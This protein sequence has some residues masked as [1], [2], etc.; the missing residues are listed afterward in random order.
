MPGEGNTGYNMK[1]SDLQMLSDM[2]LKDVEETMNSMGEGFDNTIGIIL[3]GIGLTDL[4]PKFKEN[5]IDMI[6]FLNLTD[7]DLVN[8]GIPLSQTRSKLLMGIKKFHKKDFGEDSL[9]NQTVEPF[10]MKES[11][12]ITANI[13][14]Q[15][16]LILA[17]I[18]YVNR[19]VEKG[20]VLLPKQHDQQFSTVLLVVTKRAQLLTEML[21]LQMQQLEM[22]VVQLRQKDNL[23]EADAI[24][25]WKP[26]KEDNK[27]TS[28]N[29][30]KVAL[31]GGLLIG[32]WMI[33][34]KLT[35]PSQLFNFHSFKNKISIPSKFW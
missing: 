1:Q 28:A 16:Q 33:K 29:V 6:T 8:L 17:T 15:L 21:R 19:E 20:P 23:E 13:A 12:E 9:Q 22:Q 27:L 26:N 31:A 35:F 14:K 34:D 11:V 25:S 5:N 32:L 10:T 30:V 2:S 4:L 24:T 3:E 7:S 18:Q